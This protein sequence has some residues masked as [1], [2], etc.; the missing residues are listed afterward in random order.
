[1]KFFLNY[2]SI[3]SWKE[4]FSQ[5]N[6]FCEEEIIQLAS[7][8]LN[9]KIKIFSVMDAERRD[10]VIYPHKD[11]NCGIE[12]PEE[13]FYLLFYEEAHFISPHYES[14]RPKKSPEPPMLVDPPQIQSLPFP[15]I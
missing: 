14:I 9:R 12:T 8:F 1:M 3:K 2:R 6:V 4:H 13:P 5:N 7:I 15:R 10:R 11:C